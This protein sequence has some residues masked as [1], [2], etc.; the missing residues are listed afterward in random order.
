MAALPVA[1]RWE[2]QRR[3][4]RQYA[5][6]LGVHPRELPA[7]T[8]LVKVVMTVGDPEMIREAVAQLSQ[9][10]QVGGSH[11]NT[12][13]AATHTHTHT[14]THTGTCWHEYTC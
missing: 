12:A 2:R 11:A 6:A 8:E 13:H 1:E 5:K 14:H 4:L 7:N 3:D 9:T 10:L